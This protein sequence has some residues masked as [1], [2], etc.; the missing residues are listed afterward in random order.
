L[1]YVAPDQLS[2]ISSGDGV[3]SVLDREHFNACESWARKN[4]A[5]LKVQVVID[6]HFGREGVPLELAP[7]LIDAVL[8][9]ESMVLCGIYAH[10]TNAGDFPDVQ[11][12]TRQI[13]ALAGVIASINLTDL[14]IH[15]ASSGGLLGR[16]LGPAGATMVRPGLALYG[17]WPSQELRN[18][19]EQATP[20]QRLVPVL[21]WKSIVAQVKQLSVG[22]SVGYS[23]TH[24]CDRPTTVAL[25][26]QG[27]GHGLPRSFS[28]QGAVL[29][30]QTSCPVLGRVSMN[31]LVVD[32]T[33]I[34]NV[35][36]GDS[37]VILGTQ[38]SCQITAEMHAAAT[39][40]INYEVTTRISPLLPRIIT[41]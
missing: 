4:R 30:H 27:Y 39:N 17:L 2:L 10:F 5:T 12:N 1:G 34:A 8:A 19:Y 6:A 7:E 13:T 22:D 9:S 23:R 37:V 33:H 18:F 24:I 41:P 40:T 38:G 16:T 31:M 29:I 35:R 14:D 26:P 15:I 11:V 25:I 21:Q 3:F 36:P 28:P 32:V 20:V